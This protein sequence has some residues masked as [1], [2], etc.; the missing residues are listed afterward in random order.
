[1]TYYCACCLSEHESPD[2]VCT[3]CEGDPMATMHERPAA[4]AAAWLADEANS[5]G[6]STPTP[7]GAATI[8]DDGASAIVSYEVV[9][10]IS[11]DQMLDLLKETR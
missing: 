5:G 7:V 11:H 9:A 6:G 3:D 2:F 1:M 10:Q 8:R 4:G